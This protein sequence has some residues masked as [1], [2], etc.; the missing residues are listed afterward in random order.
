MDED[1]DG[2]ATAPGSRTERLDLVLNLILGVLAVSLV[3]L[4]AWFGYSVWE[5]RQASLIA[6]PALRAIEDMKAAVR[7]S[8]ND[9]TL[10]VRLGEAYG[11]AGKFDEAIEQ[12]RAALKIE[13]EHTGAFLDLGIVALSENDFEGAK[14]Y[15]KKVVELTEGS[16]YE[17]VNNR[18]EVALFNLGGIALQERE[19]EDAIG[20]FKGSLRINKTASDTYVLLAK[21]YRG[22]EDL[23]AAEEQL[24]TA[25]AFDPN[26]AEAHFLLAQVYDQREDVVNAAVHYVEAAKLA[27]NVDPAQEAVAALGSAEERV[28]R[29]TEALANGEIEQALT[30]ALIATTLDPESVEA[31]LFHAEVLVKRG[32]NAD[33]LEVFAKVLELDPEN[34]TAKAETERLDKLVGAE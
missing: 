28:G 33:A 11:A 32:N 29:G 30:E 16:D 24:M 22:I 25:L 3:V 19:Y 23:D 6:T 1:L 14:R 21:A 17:D 20:Y 2:A 15:F 27:P 26:Y 8:P 10:R 18:R 12:L 34:E 5:T 4:V 7:Q 9:P 31:Q 13:P